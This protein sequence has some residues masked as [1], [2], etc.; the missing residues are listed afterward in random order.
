MLFLPWTLLKLF[1]HIKSNPREYLGF[2][3]FI[4]NLPHMLPVTKAFRKEMFSFDSWNYI[5]IFVVVGLVMFVFQTKRFRELAPLW[6]PFIIQLLVYWG[7]YV[8]ALGGSSWY[9]ETSLTR[10]L[11]GIVPLA[12]YATLLTFFKKDPIDISI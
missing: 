7:V 5:W 6:L 12:F 9:L 8:F 11:V 3:S 4:T 1:M 10:T 2:D